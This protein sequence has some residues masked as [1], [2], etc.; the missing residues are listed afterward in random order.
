MDTNS[1]SEKS[2]TGFLW[3]FIG[4]VFRQFSM[5]AVTVVLARIIEP[6][7]FGVIG[8]A[9]V[10]VSITQV[11]V[12][13]G[14]TQGIIQ[15]KKVSDEELSTIFYFN[16]IISIF[17]S[18]IIYLLAPIIGEF[19][20]HKQV[21]DVLRYLAIM[22]IITAFAK[23]Q[24]ALLFRNMKFKVLALRDILGTIV[25]GIVGVSA[26][27]LGFG[28]MALVFQQITTSLVITIVMWIGSK[29]IPRRYFSFNKIKNILSF[30]SYVFFDQVM[31]QI[32]MKI[33]TL[34]IGKVFSASILGFYSRAESLN[35]QIL[36]YTTAS[37]GKVIFPTLSKL[38]DNKEKF[39]EVYFK[40]FQLSA[41]IGVLLVGFLFY[42]SDYIVIGLLGDK[43]VQSAS[44]FQ[45]LVFRIPFSPYGAIMGKSILSMGHSKT[46]FKVSQIIR[47]VM[48]TPLIIGYF[49]GILG[50]CY[51]LIAA[52]AV[53]FL[54][55]TYVVKVLLGYSFFE[56]VWY[57]TKPFMPFIALLLMEAFFHFPVAN[58]IKCLL[59]LLVQITYLKVTNDRGSVLLV[60]EL[61]FA[62]KKLFKLS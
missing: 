44:I 39:K 33:D 8:M 48:I 53:V 1:L 54:I 25:G 32:F 10:F 2:R 15:K 57:F 60:N 24:S 31:R 38:Q 36:H 14:F 22:P 27:L 23:V 59:F 52:S 5:L 6:E 47:L 18:F 34:F 28:V 30:S 49:S 56:Q 19:Y 20:R 55:N 29:W 43:W 50:F 51:A 37:I 16:L 46:K 12:D 21:T 13:V 7:Q 40:F 26:A 35:S 45:I 4:T 41:T 3:D 62:R 17:L 11:I 58:F 61:K 42:M 9:M